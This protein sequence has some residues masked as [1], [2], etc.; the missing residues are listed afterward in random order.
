MAVFSGKRLPWWLAE[1]EN[2][3]RH[4]RKIDDL[5]RPFGEV[6]LPSPTTVPLD[7]VKYESYLRLL[8]DLLLLD[9]PSFPR[10]GQ[11]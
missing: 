10:E 4:L 6:R 3:E 5:K 2:D 9:L 1:A 11:C 8:G 7:E